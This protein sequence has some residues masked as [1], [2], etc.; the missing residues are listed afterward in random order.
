MSERL[1]YGATCIVSIIAIFNLQAW[2]HR[3]SGRIIRWSYTALTLALGWEVLDCLIYNGA[4]G[5]P[6]S[7][8]VLVPALGI[9]LGS[10]AFKDWR[11][12]KLF[13]KI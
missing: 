6:S 7:R 13:A 9:I 5:F 11:E 4:P 1:L 12:R 2:R 3:A 10:A 8:W